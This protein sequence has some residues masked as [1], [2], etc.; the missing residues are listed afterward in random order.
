MWACVWFKTQ[1]QLD[2]T[3]ETFIGHNRT[4]KHRL[5]HGN[6]GYQR[7]IQP[8]HIEVRRNVTHRHGY[9][10]RRKQIELQPTDTDAGQRV[11]DRNVFIGTRKHK[12]KEC[13]RHL[14]RMGHPFCMYSRHV[15]VLSGNSME[16]VK[17]SRGTS[18]VGCL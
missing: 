1:Q 5:P 6:A 9:V 18:A 10:T 14:R 3:K 4:Y 15:S 7:E 12:R 17:G 2:N 11:T 16:T 8:T 13:V